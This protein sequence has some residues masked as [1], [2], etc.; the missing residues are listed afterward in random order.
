MHYSIAMTMNALCMIGIQTNEPSKV[1][2]AV[3]S[4]ALP[5]A[6][7]CFGEKDGGVAAV[8]N[9]LGFVNS[10][11]PNYH[12]AIEA[13]IEA[14]KIFKEEDP[15]HPQ[16]AI[17]KLYLAKTTWNHVKAKIHARF[18]SGDDDVPSLL[19]PTQPYHPPVPDSDTQLFFANDIDDAIQWMDEAR[20]KFVQMIEFGE[21]QF[22]LRMVDLLGVIE[23]IYT[24]R[25]HYKALL[26]VLQEKHDFLCQ[27]YPSNGVRVCQVQLSIAK[28]L[29]LLKE[30]KRAKQLVITTVAQSDAASR[31][32][33][34]TNAKHLLSTLRQLNPIQ[35]EKK[36]CFTCGSKRGLGVCSWCTRVYFCKENNHCLKKGW[37]K[38]KNDC[39]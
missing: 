14:L 28:A 26:I 19:P 11:L 9:N 22:I 34:E 13:Y 30:Y 37:L 33:I 32:A 5:L 18:N 4:K 23:E 15:H 29:I 16:V 24:Y 39:Y 1:V 21:C 3:Q 35:N 27:L 8:L 38:H 20:L 7:Q 36:E 2:E 6:V 12:R 25:K 10:L 31:D 17:T